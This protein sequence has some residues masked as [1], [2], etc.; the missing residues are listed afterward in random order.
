M[1]DVARPNG[2]VLDPFLG[3]AKACV[4]ERFRCIGIELNP[5]YLEIAKNR[6]NELQVHLF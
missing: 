5:E 2:V 3:S 6:L 1:H 4:I